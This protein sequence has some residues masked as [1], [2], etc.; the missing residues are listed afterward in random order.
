M[1]ARLNL[2]VTVTK[3][4]AGLRAGCLPLQ[5][6]LGRFTQPKTA[7]DQRICLICN[8]ETETE[9][10]FLRLVRCKTLEESIKRLLDTVTKDLSAPILSRKTLCHTILNPQVSLYQICKSILYN[11]YVTHNNLLYC[12]T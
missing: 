9:E 11:L 6:E 1:S 4:V 7:L 12:Q 3:V 2:P 8:Q 10:H 5:I